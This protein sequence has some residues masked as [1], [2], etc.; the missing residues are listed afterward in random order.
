MN[1]PIQSKHIWIRAQ[2]TSNGNRR[3]QL[4]IRSRSDTVVTQFV[5][6]KGYTGN[7]NEEKQ[8]QRHKNIQCTRERDERSS[9]QSHLILNSSLSALSLPV[10]LTVLSGQCCHDTNCCNATDMLF[11]L[12]F[13]LAPS[14]YQMFFFRQEQ[15]QL[16]FH[17]PTG[18]L[19]STT[20]SSHVCSVFGSTAHGPWMDAFSSRQ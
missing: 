20:W 13:F 15:E 19:K 16:Y 18:S 10:T 12:L 14:P 2:C 8:G 5:T 3:V 7:Q 1:R 4:E 17:F 6:R 9:P 11:S